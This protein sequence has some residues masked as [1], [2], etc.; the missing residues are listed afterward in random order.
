MKKTDYVKKQGSH[1]L[2]KHKIIHNIYFTNFVNSLF[3]VNFNFYVS[4]QKHYNNE[5]REL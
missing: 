4:Q 1:S 5:H 2:L 3:K